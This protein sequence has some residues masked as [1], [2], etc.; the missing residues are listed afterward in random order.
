MPDFLDAIKMEAML[1]QKGVTLYHDFEQ[2][3]GFSDETPMGLRFA[4]GNE[5]TQRRFSSETHTKPR[6]TKVNED[7]RWRFSIKNIKSFYGEKTWQ[8]DTLYLGGGTPSLL[9]SAQIEDLLLHLKSCFPFTSDAEV[10]MEANPGDLSSKYAEAL[11]RSGI[12]RLN[13][14]IQSFDPANLV[15]LCRR[16]TAEDAKDSI[17][18]ARAAGFSNIG[19]DLIYGL[20]GQT[21]ES[22]MDDLNKAIDMATEHISC[23]Q[24]TIEEGTVFGRR[25]KQG[26]LTPLPDEYRGYEFFVATSMRLEQAG[27]C[28]Y[29]VSNFARDK[30]LR[31]RHNIKYW[32]HMPYLG[33]GPS[34][35]SFAGM[36]FL[37]TPKSP[38]SPGSSGQSF[39][40]GKRWWNY[41]SV[42]MYC[43]AIKDGKFPIEGGEDLTK[44]AVR[45]ESL[46][47]AFRT[48]H[49]LDMEIFREKFGQDLR[50]EPAGVLS[51]LEKQGRVDVDGE[52]IRPTLEGMAVADAMAPLF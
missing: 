7:A 14:G 17:K 36:P 18:M 39:I 20:P 30:S 23:Y 2:H 6:S 21:V 33:L 49:G 38:S 4:K 9:N 22:W 13:I 27:Y 50:K 19:I 44:D 31:S 5:N 10:T 25:L 35:H 1:Y 24:L 34:A 3:Q 29:E 37:M 41:R 45:L 26:R 48:R 51:S 28:H 15:L 12:N 52:R 43:N 8:F 32:R 11:L 16:H 46:Y 42:K 40:G 47:F